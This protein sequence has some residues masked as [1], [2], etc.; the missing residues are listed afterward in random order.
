MPGYHDAPQRTEGHQ[1]C[2]SCN[3][4]HEASN[5]LQI[6]DEATSGTVTTP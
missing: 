4:Q 5:T 2:G 3:S 1:C 6:T